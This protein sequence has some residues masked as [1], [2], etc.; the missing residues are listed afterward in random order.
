[1]SYYAKNH[2]VDD[3]VHPDVVGEKDD[4]IRQLEQEVDEA[5]TGVSNALLMLRQAEADL[6]SEYQGMVSRLRQIVQVLETL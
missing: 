3:R 4:T 2:M 6:D 1:M 5:K